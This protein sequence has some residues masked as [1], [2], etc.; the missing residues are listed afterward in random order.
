[1]I[2]REVFMEEILVPFCK[3]GQFEELDAKREGL[4]V[5]NK[6][7]RYVSPDG[8]TCPNAERFNTFAKV[9]VC[10][11]VKNRR[12]VMPDTHWTNAHWRR[13]LSTPRNRQDEPSL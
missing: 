5:P 13:T 10:R 3:L 4:A 1:M 7:G 8:S 2:Y 9:N 6:F 12:N 11:F